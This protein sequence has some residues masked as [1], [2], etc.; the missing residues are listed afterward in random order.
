MAQGR[1]QN[2]KILEGYATNEWECN[3]LEELVCLKE[4][5]CS[6]NRTRLVFA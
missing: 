6:S 2:G 1:R 4:P 5:N 3:L